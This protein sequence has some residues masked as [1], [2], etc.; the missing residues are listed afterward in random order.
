[1]TGKMIWDQRER[2][3]GSFLGLKFAA[4]TGL[5]ERFLSLFSHRRQRQDR[6]SG[7]VNLPGC[8][9]MQLAVEHN[10]GLCGNHKQDRL[11]S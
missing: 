2:G 8:A 7:A 10:G 1:M 5:P 11:Y 4:A 6:L 3:T 9:C